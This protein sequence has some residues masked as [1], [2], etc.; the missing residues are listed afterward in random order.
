M[1]EVPNEH[2]ERNILDEMSLDEF[3]REAQK[4]S[5]S[6]GKRPPPYT[7]TQKAYAVVFAKT[8]RGLGAGAGDI[9]RSL[10]IA[11]AT[12]RKW[13][14]EAYEAQLLNGEG[15][16]TEAV[17]S[18]EAG[19]NQ[20]EIEIGTRAMMNREL[21]LEQ[22][23]REQRKMGRELLKQERNKEERK[24]KSSS[25][26]SDTQETQETRETRETP[27]KRNGEKLAKAENGRTPT[28][29]ATTMAM[30]IISDRRSDSPSIITPRGYRIE[31]LNVNSLVEV[32]K[33]LETA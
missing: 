14:D 19:N 9:V 6:H 18:D 33:Q 1:I 24:A 17:M 4:R 3:R 11:A 2:E 28:R 25:M 32:L 8:Q 26:T 22:E 10:G 5:M 7:D 13:E 16:E 23:A 31:G 20:R 15:E 21:P 29:T 12:L 27:D 30:E